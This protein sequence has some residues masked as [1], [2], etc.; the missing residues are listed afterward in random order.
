VQLTVVEPA[1]PAHVRTAAA[2]LEA[3]DRLGRKAIES[4]TGVSMDPAPQLPPWGFGPAPSYAYNVGT[5]AVRIVEV[6]RAAERT[7][8]PR[9]DAEP[10]GNGDGR[11]GDAGE[12]GGDP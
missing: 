9:D 7:D 3:A 12:G 6:G 11:H 10:T 1:T 4:M 2:V 5:P 8:G